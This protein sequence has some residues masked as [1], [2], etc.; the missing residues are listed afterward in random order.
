MI[1]VYLADDEK[2]V[3]LGLQKLIQ[4]SGLPF[5]VIGKADNGEAAWEGIC[6]LRPQVLFTDIRM[7]KMSGTEL[8]HRIA[9]EGLGVR[10]VLISGYAEF[11]YAQSALRDGAFDYILK[12]IKEEELFG[13]LEKLS[14]LFMP[15]QALQ[16]DLETVKRETVDEVV[17]E[18]QERYTEDISLQ[19]LAQKHHISSG[20]LSYLLKQK[21]G[22]SFSKYLLEKRIE[23][24]KELL[25][26]KSLS[27]DEVAQRVG[28]HDYFY[29]TKVFKE[30][31]GIS[32]SKFRKG[33]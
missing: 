3:L 12:P 21:L 20:H 4:K 24:A 9:Q 1:S 5:R 13:I 8:L 16:K 22:V 30:S 14:A 19:G 17:R 26:D 31:Q 23:L 32:P 11:G 33:G 7:P 25:R 6:A 15:K 29:F 27:I 18:I 2:W 10:T 28:Y